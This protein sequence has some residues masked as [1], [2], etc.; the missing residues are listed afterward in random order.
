VA[1]LEGIAGVVT[2]EMRHEQRRNAGQGTD[3]VCFGVI[4]FVFM[5]TFSFWGGRGS[6]WQVETVP[7]F[8]GHLSGEEFLESP[9]NL[10]GGG[11]A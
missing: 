2:G 5:Q 10:F 4:S 7:F 8:A 3:C 9:Q 1:I 11:I 6:N